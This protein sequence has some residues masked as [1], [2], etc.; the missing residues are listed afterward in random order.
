MMISTGVAVLDG[1]IRTITTI[2]ITVMATH[3]MDTTITIIMDMLSNLE[4]IMDV[5]QLWDLKQEPVEH[6][7]IEVQ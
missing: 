5:E 4:T 3:T 6:T 7:P 2:L 1:D